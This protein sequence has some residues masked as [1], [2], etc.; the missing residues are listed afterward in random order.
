[1][2]KL[3]KWI[4]VVIGLLVLAAAGLAIYGNMKFKPTLSNRSLQAITADTSPEGL[5]RENI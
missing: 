5:A 2:R 1:M 4:G 3:L